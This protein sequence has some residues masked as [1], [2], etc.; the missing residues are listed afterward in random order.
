MLYQDTHQAGKAQE[1]RQDRI[2]DSLFSGNEHPRHHGR[3]AARRR[4]RLWLLFLA[5]LIV[6]IVGAGTLRVDQAARRS[7][8]L[9]RLTTA[10]ARLDEVVYMVYDWPPNAECTLD[11]IGFTEQLL[12][13]NGREYPAVVARVKGEAISGQALAREEFILAQDLPVLTSS[14][15]KQLALYALI[16][17]KLLLKEGEARG[18]T[19]D[20][21]E[22]TAQLRE[23]QEMLT[24]DGDAATQAIL[25]ASLHQLG[26]TTEQYATDPRVIKLL[27]DARIVLR[28]QE[29]ILRAMPDELRGTAAGVRTATRQ[30]ILQHADQVEI[31][32]PYSEGFLS[33]ANFRAEEW[34][35]PC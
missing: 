6:T 1:D 13:V 5:G 4:P 3:F 24:Q 2:D 7:A 15:R 18:Y 17:K 22:I 21:A 20:D 9:A 35:G 23:T 19:V 8:D 29:D 14:E 30:F 26:I 34:F 16:E 28:L 25:A 27:H 31:L 32:I 10:V 33:D 11:P 12:Q